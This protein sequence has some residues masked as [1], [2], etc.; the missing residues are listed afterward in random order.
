MD[1]R[2]EPRSKRV[3]RHTQKDVWSIQAC[4]RRRVLSG[5]HNSGMAGEGGIDGLDEQIKSKEVHAV[6]MRHSASVHPTCGGG[7]QGSYCMT[8]IEHF[9]RGHVV[10]ARARSLL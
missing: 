5:L 4:T 2:A 8:L 1:N 3:Y 6:S 9:V 7:V 10:L